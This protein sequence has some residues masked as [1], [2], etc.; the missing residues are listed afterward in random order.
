MPDT[1]LDLANPGGRLDLGQPGVL[2]GYRDL[3]AV[4]NSAIRT[5]FQFLRALYYDERQ[6][7]PQS[8]VLGLY[9]PSQ[10]GAATIDDAASDY[11]HL[12]VR[13]G[14]GALSILVEPGYGLVYNSGALPDDFEIEEYAPVVLDAQASTAAAA[15][16]A[17]NP[18]IDLVVAYAAFENDLPTV[19]NVRNPSTQVETTPSI[20]LRRK[21]SAT[22]SVV[23]GTAAASP[24]PPAVPTGALLLAEVLV[25][26]TSGPI[27]VTD[28]RLYLQPTSGQVKSAPHTVRDCAVSVSAPA[29]VVVGAGVVSFGGAQRWFA[30]GTYPCVFAGA[31]GEV[32][33]FAV[34]LDEGGAVTCTVESSGVGGVPLVPAALPVGEVILAWGYASTGSIVLVESWPGGNVGN[35][36]L[37]PLSV[38]AR[39]VADGAITNSKIA[40][41][42][43]LRRAS[44]VGSQFTT[45]EDFT[46]LDGKLSPAAASTAYVLTANAQLPDGVDIT[47]VTFFVETGG[48]TVSMAGQIRELDLATGV[49]THVGSSS[50]FVTGT[51]AFQLAMSAFTT[52]NANKAYYVELAFTSPATNWVD[53]Q[54]K[55]V[56]ITY[57]SSQYIT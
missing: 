30:G 6:L 17:T 51:I 7:V 13:K 52:D 44:I 47:S 42:H 12:F 37:A 28:R 45:T 57:S 24:V 23:T 11:P 46:I 4:G 27:E 20:D 55:G 50:G 32:E 1:N 5:V 33:S 34:T 35:S 40:L 3:D 26:A 19:R 14:G 49:S 29:D 39:N 54:L 48:E 21:Y 9:Q 36:S 56:S 8:G 38:E 41:S 16:H 22:I 25:P 53:T 15:H 10:G 18:R 31:A 2:F 43:E